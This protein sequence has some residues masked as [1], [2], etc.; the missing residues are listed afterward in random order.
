MEENKITVSETSQES[1]QNHA[2]VSTRK[3]SIFY[4]WQSDI[5][6]TR[7]LI[8]DSIDEAIDLAQEAIAID[9]ERDEATK[10]TT[11]SPN[12]VTTLFSKIDTCDLFI[13]DISLCYKSDQKGNKRAP[14][15]NVLLELGYA[16]KT[17]GW[18]RVICLCNTDYGE[19]YPFDISHNRITKFSLAEINREEVKYK[20]AKIIFQNIRDLKN[21]QPRAKSNMAT[22]IVGGYDVRTHRVTKAITPIIIGQ[23]ESY[24]LHNEE[25]LSEAKKLLVEIE[26][27]TS[28]MEF[29][30]ELEAKEKKKVIE[31]DVTE[32][33]WTESMSS[34]EELPKKAQPM[35]TDLLRALKSPVVWRDS[36]EDEDRI[37]YWLGKNVSKNFFDLGGLETM[38]GLSLIGNDKLEGTDNEKEKYNMLRKMSYVLHQLDLRTCYIGTFNGMCFIPLAIHNISSLQDSDIRVVVTVDV[39]EI[40][41]PDENLISDELKGHQGLLC[42][43]DE[44]DDIGVI[45]ELFIL[46][47]DGI[48]HVEPLEYDVSSYIPKAPL[49]NGSGY[50]TSFKTENDYKEELKEFI[51]SSDRNRHYEFDIQK[52]RPN[53]CRWLSTGML[54]KPIE[55][56]ISVHYQI[57]STHS[58]GTLNGMLDYRCC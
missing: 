4:S 34:K 45:A 26:G 15:P 35:S 10:N 23:Q 44:D 29:N 28:K 38:K 2:D 43:N 5:S 18:E 20:I 22:H 21:S 40:V 48:I 11:G 49:F 36:T 32:I 50:S 51:A 6:K 39:G 47:E 13:A 31:D 46:P 12:I 58:D 1:A 14:N 41:E 57:H 3:F 52:L 42:R 24:T 33:P 37:R 55:N 54:I 17:L 9:A 16:V 25:L 30:K 19:E 27:L 7:Y 56:R 8:R 53:E